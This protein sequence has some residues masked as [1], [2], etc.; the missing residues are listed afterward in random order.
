MRT[1]LIFMASSALLLTA[2]PPLAAATPRATP[3]PSSLDWQSCDEPQFARWQRIDG[4]I[5]PGFQC[6]VLTRP[7]VRSEPGGRKVRLAVVRLPASGTPE[8]YRGPLVWNP[9]GPGQTGVGLSNIVYLLPPDVRESF[10]FV[11][12]DP[13]GIGA[14]TPAIGGPGCAI[15]KPARPATGP[16]DWQQVLTARRSQ[17]RR[18]NAKCYQGNRA[19]IE[20]AGTLDNAHDLEALRTALGHEQ[21]TYWGLSYGTL[22][23]STYMQLFPDR[24][25]AAVQDS[26]MDPQL[27]LHGVNAGSV[28]PDH[29]LGFFL[30]ANPDIKPQYNAVI[31]ALT[32]RTLGLPD[33][34]R[35]TRWDVLDVLNDSVMFYI[36]PGGDWTAAEQVI[37]TAHTALFGTGATRAAA[38]RALTQPAFRSPRTGTVGGLWSAVVCQD[39]ADRLTAGEQRSQMRW[40]V[41]NGP[42]YGGSLG[43]DYITTCDGY[44]AAEPDPVPTPRRFGPEIPGIIS[45]ST[46]DGETPYQWAVNM[47]RVYRK[48]RMLTLVGG[49]HGTFGLSQSACV[50]N[51]IAQ[52]LISLQRPTTDLTCP[53]SPPR[54]VP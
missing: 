28:A 18:L 50:D 32:D 2:I 4:T 49:L 45:N 43:V 47:A 35:Y 5:F 30:E 13:R 6:A 24:V 27:R 39:F 22:L 51:T 54:P 26:N 44:G 9:G 29:S 15:P 25:R 34:T 52:F 19:I 42:V 36:D 33:G 48:M 7:L 46:R 11:T 17:V 16:V 37:T 40:A 14:S 20:N 12:W 1:S 41:R 3:A 53:W 31:R 23:G 10:D 21:I 8:Q 38:R